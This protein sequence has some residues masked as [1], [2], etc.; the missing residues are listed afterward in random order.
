MDIGAFKIQD[1]IPEITN[2]Y[3]IAMIKPWVDVGKVGTLTLNRIERFFWC[4]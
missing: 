4:H 2:P 3:V 1:D